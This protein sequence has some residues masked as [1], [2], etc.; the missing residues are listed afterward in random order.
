MD[1]ES[2]TGVGVHFTG[3]LVWWSRLYRVGHAHGDIEEHAQKLLARLRNYLALAFHRFLSGKNGKKVSITLDIFDAD[4]GTEGIP[5][6]VG[7]LNPFGYA[8]KWA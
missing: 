2:W 8:A 1:P 7:P 6:H 5:L 4:T 3:T